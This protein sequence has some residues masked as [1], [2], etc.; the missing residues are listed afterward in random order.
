M[1]AA[2][3]GAQWAFTN[4]WS[5]FNNTTPQSNV[6]KA[7]INSTPLDTSVNCTTTNSGNHLVYSANPATNDPSL[8]APNFSLACKC[9]DGTALNNPSP[10][11]TTPF[12]PQDCLNLTS[13]SCNFGSNNLAAPGAYV[14]V[15][16]KYTYTPLFGYLGFGG[17]MMLQATSTQRIQ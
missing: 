16:T 17:P 9:V 12:K 15:R 2:Q 4:G 10:N 7:A 8:G 11:T 6:C 5:N 3:S 14:T 13:N 1:T